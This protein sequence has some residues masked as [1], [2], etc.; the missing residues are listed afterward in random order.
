MQEG[1]E[2]EKEPIDGTQSDTNHGCSAG[3][4]PQ[5]T[6]LRMEDLL[7]RLGGHLL[8]YPGTC[9]G[10]GFPWSSS[11]SAHGDVCDD[12]LR[13]CDH[14]PHSSPKRASRLASRATTILALDLRTGISGAK[15]RRDHGN[16]R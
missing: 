16:T 6:S 7:V 1:R 11:A 15:R 5:L 2:K 13:L 9:L 14:S 12:G 3:E 8:A 10:A 4:A